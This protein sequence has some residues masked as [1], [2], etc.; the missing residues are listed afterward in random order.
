[1]VKRSDR[2]PRL[3]EASPRRAKRRRGGRVWPQ[4]K[5][6]AVLEA[7]RGEKS[8]AEICQ[9][10]GISQS[11]F[12]G[13]KE[14]FLRGAQEY[15]EHGGMSAGEKAARAENRQLEKAL[16]RETLDKRIIAEALEKLRDPRWRERAES[17]E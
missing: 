4:H 8:V 3:G 7:L 6:E 10:R 9:A 12:F 14:Q 11:T 15:L 1:M 5:L 13:W 2:K 16:A 17:S